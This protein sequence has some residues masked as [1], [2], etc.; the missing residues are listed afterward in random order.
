MTHSPKWRAL[1]A[2]EAGVLSESSAAFLERHV[3]A[4]EVCQDALARIR[5]YAE[6]Q[7]EIQSQ[8]VPEVP[9]RVGAEAIALAGVMAEVAS[10]PAPSFDWDRMEA[11]ITK[12]LRERPRHEPKWR[13]LLA[14]HEGALSDAGR[15]RVEAHLKDCEICSDALASMGAYDDV[16]DTIRTSAPPVVDFDRMSLPVRRAARQQS[17]QRWVVA[18]VL[19][20]AAAVALAIL[21]RS[22]ATPEEPTEAPSVAVVEETPPAPAAALEATVVAVGGRATV[23][24]QQV[25]VGT[26]LVEED[27]LQLA[28]GAVHVR[29]AERT[30][31]S[32]NGDAELGLIALREDGVTLALRHGRV[33][34][35]VRTGT[36]YLI[37]AAGY[38]VQVRGTR[39]DVRREE[40]RV[41]VTV[42]EGVV[43]V[44]RGEEVVALLPAPATWTSHADFSPTA[45]GGVAVARALE[46]GDD[47]WPVLEVPELDHIVRWEIDGT[48]FDVAGALAMRV[49]PRELDIVGWDRRGR[50]HVARIA[51][52]DEGSVLEAT[53]LAPARPAAGYIAPDDIQAVVQPTVRRLQRCYERTLRQMNPTL[54][55]SYALR[56]TVRRDG[57]V[58]RVRVITDAEA[59]PPFVGCLQ[60]VASRWTFPSPE[61][62][63]TAT[64]QLPLSFSSR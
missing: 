19:A 26:A 36:H 32:L 8:T 21:G 59:P 23:A 24:D 2:W 57:T 51:M 58:R 60:A 4:C 9:E 29:I 52:A 3:A 27:V 56:V 10:A 12:A 63:P 31:F 35:Q 1:L 62:G 46:A 50:R 25:E 28:A 33:S 22:P 18:T 34:S 30:G 6:V 45:L 13:A 17:G 38:T 14:Y 41:A 54:E 16:A 49:P 7:R 40:E 48:P 64:F 39:F 20:M 61:G 55:G 53:A 44:R 37:E 15:A 43:E 5:G 47:N 11:N 42:D